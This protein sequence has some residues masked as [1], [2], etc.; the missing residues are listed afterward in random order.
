METVQDLIDYLNTIEDK[1]VSIRLE[2]KDVAKSENNHNEL[3][4]IDPDTNRWLVSADYRPTGTP[5]YEEYGE[6]V[7]Y[8]WDGN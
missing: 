7:L 2:L 3:C 4:Y 5:G 1:D 6:V 8:D